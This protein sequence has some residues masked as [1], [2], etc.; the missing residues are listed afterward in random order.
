MLNLLGKNVWN[1]VFISGYHLL[2]SGSTNLYLLLQLSLWVHFTWPTSLWFFFSSIFIFNHP[3]YKGNI[4]CGR[5]RPWFTYP[6][7]PSIYGWCFILRFLGVLAAMCFLITWGMWHQVHGCARLTGH[8]GVII[9]RGCFMASLWVVLI[10]RLVL[11]FLWFLALFCLGWSFLCLLFSHEEHHVSSWPPSCFWKE[12]DAPHWL[13]G[14]TVKQECWL[15]VS[16]CLAEANVMS[17]FES[18]V[19]NL[20]WF[21]FDSKERMLY[22]STLKP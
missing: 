5:G 6:A 21:V 8:C 18:L 13:H 22:P 12:Q 16:W 2:I 15:I 20:N 10:L 11:W 19:S 3:F 4:W 7:C 9:Q 1:Y 17:K 14:S